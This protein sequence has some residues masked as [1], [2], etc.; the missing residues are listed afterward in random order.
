MDIPVAVCDREL[1][2]GI[3]SAREAK[4]APWPEWIGPDLELIVD[5]LAKRR[6]SENTVTA[7]HRIT[8]KRHT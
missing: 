5:R 4:W 2:A 8:P 7:D 6:T 3:L 1:A